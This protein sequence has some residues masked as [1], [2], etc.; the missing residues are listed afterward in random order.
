[1][2]GIN[3]DEIIDF[4]EWGE[5]ELLNVRFIE[6]MPL[7]GEDYF[8][9]LKRV[10]HE[11]V[12]EKNLVSVDVSGSGPARNFK[13]EGGDSIIG[14]ILP[15]SAPFCKD[16][17]RLRLT[18]NGILLPCLFST[19]GFDFKKVLREGGD[20]RSLFYEAVSRK[21]EKH[22]LNSIGQ[23]QYMNQIGG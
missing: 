8:Y 6:F 20:I 18:S 2:R 22:N 17:N 11:I 19:K 14:F 21:P 3:D 7:F 15:R 5:R 12:K 13:P 1:M 10:M 16:C 9:L 4:I 23:Y